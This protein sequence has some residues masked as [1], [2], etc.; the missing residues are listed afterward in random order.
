MS[1]DLSSYMNMFADEA[2]EHLQALNQALLDFE[3]NSTDLEIVNVMFR[4]AHTLKGMS[5]TM[6]FTAVAELTHKMENLLTPIRQGDLTAEDSTIELLFHCLDALQEM[7]EAHISGE[8]HDVDISSLV[9]QLEA[10]A[11]AEQTGLPQ[12]AAPKATTGYPGEV[13][14]ELKHKIIAARN[15]GKEIFHVQVTL[16]AD[17]ELK[18]A[19]AFMVL[20]ELRSIGEIL[21]SVPDEHVLTE[22][23]IDQHFDL[24]F[25]STETMEEIEHTG[26][27]VLEIEKVTVSSFTEEVGDEPATARRVATDVFEF[28]EYDLVVLKHAQQEKYR[29]VHAHV[30][31]AEDCALK[32]ARAFMVHKCLEELGE[33]ISVVPDVEDIEFERFERDLDFLFV[34]KAK[35]GET[36]KAI[37]GISEIEFVE[38]DEDPPIPSTPGKPKPAAK[39]SAAAPTAAKETTA[40]AKPTAAAVKKAAPAAAEKARQTQ[41]IRVDTDRLDKLL[42]LVGELVIG[43]TR[44]AQLAGDVKSSELTETIEQMDLVVSDLQNVVMQTRMVP[45]ETVFNRFPRMIRDLAKARGKQVELKMT[46]GE[47]ELDRTVIDEL[48]DPLV[49]LIRNALD[50]GI[51]TAEERAAANKPAAGTLTL[52]AYHE[53]SS[54]FIEI[55]DDGRGID[56]DKIRRSAVK[57]GIISEEEAA[58][59]NDQQALDLI[60]AAGLSTADKVT[61]ISGRGVGMDVVKNKLEQLNGRVKLRTELGTGSTFTIKLPLTLAIVQALM[62]RIAKEDYAIPLAYIEQ[63]LR[64]L[65]DDIQKVNR[66][67]VVLLRGEILPLVNMHELLDS[68]DGEG[69]DGAMFAVVV[70]SGGQRVGLC[71][72][73]TVGQLEIVIKNLGKYLQNTKYIAGGTI[74]GDGTVALILDVAH[75]AG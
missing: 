63:T 49:H 2:R 56:A 69:R 1:L 60:F 59:L 64:L 29:I 75:I 12:P 57:R 67:E 55:R 72:D 18:N 65:P 48:G 19:R 32:S 33:I 17:C 10:A 58:A 43:K 27:S 13:D 31:L 44:L 28:N 36:R 41:T 40:I 52:S 3:K 51:E 20:R 61:D 15:N 21:A 62:V 6:G 42:N 30:I 38:V 35:P 26:S 23:D 53:G 47:T 39:D 8:E 54:V 7:V 24:L 22:G 50:H 37:D 16:A 71:V 46:G 68:P 14:V 11:G 74:L 4:S 66:Q 45:I 9:A 5:A 70:Q 73:E 25:A 34:T